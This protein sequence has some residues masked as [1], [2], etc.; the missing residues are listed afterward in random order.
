MY[1]IY[2]E[3]Y[4]KQ[5]PDDCSKRGTMI[6]TQTVLL[7]T[8]K[9]TWKPGLFVNFA[10]QIKNTKSKSTFIKRI[11]HHLKAR[12]TV[13]SRSI[14]PRTEIQGGALPPQIFFLVM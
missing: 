5:L 6:A 3:A 4:K 14:N 9:R 12:N 10:I 11:Y 1:S 7:Y 8:P 13:K 2:L